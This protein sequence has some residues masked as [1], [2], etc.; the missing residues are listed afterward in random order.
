MAGRPTV[1]LCSGAKPK[2]VPPSLRKRAKMLALEYRAGG[3][4]PQNIDL[5]LPSFISSVNHLPPRT[6]DLLEIAAYVFSADR[7]LS[8]G[9]KDAVEFNAWSRDIRYYIR[10][11][12]HAF[13]SSKDVGRLLGSALEWVTGD[14]SHSFTFLPGHSTPATSLFDSEQFQL[15]VHDGARVALFS[16]GIDSLAGATDFLA[17]ATGDLYLIS[18]QSGAETQRTQ[19]ALF[20]AIR[21]RFPG[22]AQRYA[23]RCTLK[24]HRA[25][26]ET[27][28]TRSFLFSAIAFGLAT[29]LRQDS[30][31][32][33]ENGVTSLNLPKREG[34]WHARASRTTHP[35]TIR[36]FEALLSK[37]AERPFSIHV[38]FFGKTKAEVI[39]V[40]ENAGSVDLLDSSVS[41][42]RTFKNTPHSTHCGGC[43]QCVDR[44]FAAIAAGAGDIDHAGLYALDILRDP[45][46]ESEAKTFVVDYLSQAREFSVLSP[47]GFEKKYLTELT[48]IVDHLP[49]IPSGEEINAIHQLCQRHGKQIMEAV[50]SLNDPTAKPKPDTLL[51]LI[52][53][54]EYLKSP[55]ERLLEAVCTKLARGIPAMFKQV[56]P[57]NENDFNDKVD[58]LLNSAKPEFDREH[59]TVSFARAKMVPDHLKAE[60]GIA[61]ESKYV[62]KGT[63]PSKATDGIAADMFKLPAELFKLMVV[64]DPDRS[65]TDDEEFAAAFEA[66][67]NCRVLVVR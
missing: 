18:H 20:T 37:V 14:V 56:P 38:P 61:I 63:S 1:V 51:A 29:A 10:V 21:S 33:Y 30:F 8:R 32:L 12:D 7:W 23:F 28:R 47:D 9:A 65:I 2:S 15:G 66:R 22:R 53:Q 31:W 27:Q 59:P 11:R 54:R 35:R 67:G 5:G 6:I 46:T 4:L 57:K 58:A 24:G 52:A 60:N 45:L 36:S 55:I 64:Y 13:W 49:T 3:G 16:G 19:A 50:R 43:S 34:M 44:R 41:C 25:G 39:Q 62:R 26:D 42:T 40:L 48:D 17:N